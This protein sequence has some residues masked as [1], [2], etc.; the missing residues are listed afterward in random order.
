MWYIVMG[1]LKGDVC[2][3]VCKVFV[4]SER[5]KDS[6]VWLRYILVEI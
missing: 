6:T 1:L 4:T 2:A 5:L 3:R